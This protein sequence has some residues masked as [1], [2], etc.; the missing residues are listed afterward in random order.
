MPLI[1]GAWSP[2]TRRESES[3]AARGPP[4]MIVSLHS[5]A[6]LPHENVTLEIDPVDDGRTIIIK[7]RGNIEM[8]LG[9][10]PPADAPF[11]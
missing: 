9:D 3:P 6:Q 2:R 10:S 11:H 7:P 5:V 1:E 8:G 4:K